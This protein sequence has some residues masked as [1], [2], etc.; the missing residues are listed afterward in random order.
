MPHRPLDT[1][2]A[3]RVRR[4]R[5][6]KGL[7]QK[8]LGERAGVSKTTIESYERG[9]LPRSTYVAKLADALD[10][11]AHHL[12]HGE[13]ATE[14]GELIARVRELQKRVEASEA[15]YAREAQAT[16]Q[17]IEAVTMQLRQLAAIFP[18]KL[19][20][21]LSIDN[22]KNTAPRQRAASRH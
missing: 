7:T 5:G 20:E 22:G 19:D 2:F 9:Q 15:L 13:E 16:R 21:L 10:V 8:Q 4:L 14:L 1:E 17:V 18:E 11:S 12:L 3:E 6:G